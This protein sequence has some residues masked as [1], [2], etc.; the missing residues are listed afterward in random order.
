[1]REWP[2]LHLLLNSCSKVHGYPGEALTSAVLLQRF[3]TG[4]RPEIDCQ[5]LLHQKPANFN[6]GVKDAMAIEYAL[7]FGREDNTIHSV[8]QKQKT[9]E[10]AP[11]TL[12]ALIK[13]LESLEMTIQKSQVKSRPAEKLGYGQNQGQRSHCIGTVDCLLGAD[14]L[15]SHKVIIDYKHI[16]VVIKG[17]KIPFTLT[18]GV[19]NTIL[20]PNSLAVSALKNRSHSPTN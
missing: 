20:P 8:W 15:I 4:L 10:E 11:N 17:H 18:H 9:G 1:M 2:I 16:N 3:L 14:Y 6:A 19:A 5:L 13:R 7:E 12:H